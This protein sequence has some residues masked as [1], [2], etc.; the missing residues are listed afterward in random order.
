MLSTPWRYSLCV[1]SAMGV[2]IG[3]G[4]M[5]RSVTTTE[6]VPQPTERLSQTVATYIFEE[7][8]ICG[9]YR[10]THLWK[11]MSLPIQPPRRYRKGNYGYRIF[12][13]PHE[14]QKTYIPRK[15]EFL[16]QDIDLNLKH[17]SID[18][19]YCH[20]HL[21]RV[22]PQFPPRFLTG[23]TSGFCKF[24]VIFDESGLAS[25]IDI[26]NCTDEI[27]ERPTRTAVQKWRG[28]SDINTKTQRKTN[29]VR[30]QLTDENGEILP[31]P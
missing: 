7:V 1:L 24:S 28:C 8:I 26:I 15:P 4:L 5:I 12:E 17:V 6:F 16:I 23:K 18:D 21:L 31:Y 9:G 2:T 3:L 14:N 19:G 22:P 25:D 29:T 27:L 11:L 30:Y 13:N 10:D 20:D